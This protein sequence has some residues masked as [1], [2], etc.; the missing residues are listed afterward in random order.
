MIWLRLFQNNLTVS[1][2]GSSLSWIEQELTWYKMLSTIFSASLLRTYVGRVSGL[3]WY[4]IL[5]K[6]SKTFRIMGSGISY[7][8]VNEVW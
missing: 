2:G 3:D 6:Q 4:Q 7:N 8:Y 1:M 5:I